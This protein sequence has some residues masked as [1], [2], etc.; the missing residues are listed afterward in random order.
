MS[1]SNRFHEPYGI[2]FKGFEVLTEDYGK[3]E[4]RI[5]KHTQSVGGLAIFG[6]RPPRRL[7]RQLD[8]QA[9]GSFSGTSGPGVH[10]VWDLQSGKEL[11]QQAPAVTLHYGGRLFLDGRRLVTGESEGWLRLWGVTP[12]SILP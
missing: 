12:P 2:R 6:P 4:L 5:D 3:A 10:R 7:V 1:V 9:S 8:L 11:F